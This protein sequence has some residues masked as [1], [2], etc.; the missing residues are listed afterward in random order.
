MS[1]Y[2]Y[3]LCIIYFALQRQIV[4]VLTGWFCVF[5]FSL[6]SLPPSCPPFPALGE[7]RKPEFGKR[8]RVRVGEGR[9]VGVANHLFTFGICIMRQ[10]ANG[11]PG[12]LETGWH[13]FSFNGHTEE[14]SN[15]S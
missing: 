13:A 14:T 15:P 2:N 8:D 5:L 11:S 4:L 3:Y 6:P 1:Y 12:R 9:M 7:E 10:G